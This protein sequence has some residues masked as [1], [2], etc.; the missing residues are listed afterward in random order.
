MVRIIT[1]SYCGF[2]QNMFPDNVSVLP[3]SFNFA[4][5][6][7]TVY[8]DLA[9]YSNDDFYRRL[10]L[11]IK[12]NIVPLTKEDILNTIKEAAMKGEDVLCLAPSY[13]VASSTVRAYS[14]AVTLAKDA[15][16]A[17]NIEYVTTNNISVGMGLLVKDLSKMAEEGY[18]LK[19]LMV[20]INE[21]INRYKTIFYWPNIEQMRE[22]KFISPIHFKLH[23]LCNTMP[24][25]RMDPD[26]VLRDEKD[27]KTF[28]AAQEYLRNNVDEHARNLYVVH[29]HIEDEAVEF[30]ATLQN[31]HDTKVSIVEM[32][33]TLG[34]I[35]GPKVL[36][37]SY[38]K[39]NN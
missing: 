7:E 19:E 15:Y 35:M 5:E 34:S 18:S 37:L 13:Y 20:Y 36:G 28:S 39:K 30:A 27:V 11:G 8:R 23:K 3:V 29:S 14:D 12:A 4:G 33:K 24:I 32:N 9:Y 38:Y 26:G 25:Y 6:E 16:P 10:S 1:D 2:Y 17:L 21:N 31:Y 22:R